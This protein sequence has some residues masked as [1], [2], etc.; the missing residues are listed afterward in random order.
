MRCDKGERSRPMDRCWIFPSPAIPSLDP[1]PRAP[2]RRAFQAR[3]R[4]I[5]PVDHAQVAVTAASP[6]N[7]HSGTHRDRLGSAARCRS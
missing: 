1:A 2:A 3:L 6:A 7:S 4:S 5:V